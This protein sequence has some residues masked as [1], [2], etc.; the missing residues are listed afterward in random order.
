[1]CRCEMLLESRLFAVTAIA[2]YTQRVSDPSLDATQV[3]EALYFIDHVCYF[4]H[5][6]CPDLFHILS[7]SL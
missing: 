5:L 3:R 6:G 4:C 2:N 7:T 1:M